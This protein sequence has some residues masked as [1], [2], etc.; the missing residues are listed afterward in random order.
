MESQSEYEKALAEYRAED[1]KIHSVGLSDTDI[2]DEKKSEEHTSGTLSIKSSI[3]GIVVER[4]VVIGQSV[5]VTTNAF[6]II[7]I[8]S[9][10]VD[11]QVYEKDI[12]KIL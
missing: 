8:S 6:K 2:N 10:W 3:N 4:N 1:K 11:G 5:D 12:A 9:V 7:N